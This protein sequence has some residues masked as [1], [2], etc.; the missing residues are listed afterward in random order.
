[1]KRRV[2]VVS[3]INAMQAPPFITGETTIGVKERHP[4]MELWTGIEPGFITAFYKGAEI[5]IP[6]ANVTNS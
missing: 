4:G 5:G 6:M 2:N 3:V 1:M